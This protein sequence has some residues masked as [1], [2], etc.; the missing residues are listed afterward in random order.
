[1]PLFKRTATA[2]HACVLYIFGLPPTHNNASYAAVFLAAIDLGLLLHCTPYHACDWVVAGY[3]V[4][5]FFISGL[6]I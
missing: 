6:T 5:H 4:V 3:V 1:M 2:D